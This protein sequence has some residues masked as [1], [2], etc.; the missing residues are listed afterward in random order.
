[1]KNGGDTGNLQV[2]KVAPSQVLKIAPI[3]VK[4]KTDNARSGTCLRLFFSISSAKNSTL[5]IYAMCRA[6][7]IFLRKGSVSGVR[8]VINEG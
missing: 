4:M 3:A 5:F 6:L 7:S 1:M 8:E 2:P